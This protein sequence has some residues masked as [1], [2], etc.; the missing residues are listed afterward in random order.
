MPEDCK[1]LRPLAP[2]PGVAPGHAPCGSGHRETR[3]EYHLVKTKQRAG[4]SVPLTR[5][6]CRR[7]SRQRPP[8]GL[9]VVRTGDTVYYPLTFSPRWPA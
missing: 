6:T 7:P 9:G 8:S 1:S 2:A 4:G 3:G 5:R